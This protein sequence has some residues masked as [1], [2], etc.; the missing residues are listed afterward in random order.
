MLPCAEFSRLLVMQAA[1][2]DFWGA[3]VDEG[4]YCIAHPLRV[5]GPA[6]G[7][8]AAGLRP[9]GWRAGRAVWP[10]PEEG[11]L[12][13]A[14][15]G[16]PA[17]HQLASGKASVAIAFG[18][19]DADISS[20]SPQPN[21]VAERNIAHGC[22][23]CGRPSFS[24][25]TGPRSGFTH[26]CPWPAGGVQAQHLSF[27]SSVHIPSRCRASQTCEVL[28]GSPEKLEGDFLLRRV[29]ATQHLL[30]PLPLMSLQITAGLVATAQMREGCQPFT[31]QHRDCH[32]GFAA[33]RAMARAC[34][35]VQPLMPMSVPGSG[36][37]KQFT[38]DKQP[39]LH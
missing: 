6:R 8:G 28:E 13:L 27:C 15:G 35:P 10:G 39:R 30:R 14:A 25:H 23:G 20:P 12:A 9:A 37:D 32:G 4:H 3:W 5:P 33:P 36:M 2:A 7:D 31:L 19:L 21:G 24:S 29:N 18:L 26:H 1:C 34:Q 38:R 17:S 22:F 11:P 16:H